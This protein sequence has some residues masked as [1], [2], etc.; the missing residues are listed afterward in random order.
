MSYLRLN[1]AL[2]TIAMLLTAML[3]TPL[4]AAAENSEPSRTPPV[5]VVPINTEPAAANK[6]PLPEAPYYTG[7]GQPPAYSPPAS[8]A[9]VAAPPPDFY[10]RARHL[11]GGSRLLATGGISPLEGA[12]GGG[13]VPWALISGLGDRD[14]I[15]GSAY[16]TQAD[17][18][19]FSLR[20]SGGA[21][22]FFNRVELSYAHLDFGLG[23][24]VPGHSIGLDVIGAKLRVYGDAVYDQDSLIP[25]ISVGVQHKHN[26]DFDLVPKALGARRSDDNDYYIAATKIFLAGLAGRNV[27]ANLTLRATRANQLGIL[28][29]GGDQGDHYQVLPEASLGVFLADHWLVGGEYRMKP[30]NLSVFREDDFKDAFLVWFPIKRLSLTAAWAWLGNIADQD[31]QDALYLSG[32]LAF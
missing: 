28:G 24:T 18:T 22:G 23:T 26:K 8:L 11:V 27:V 3:V 2:T 9:V 20:S 10:D 25:Q 5:D 1:L 29:F 4:S 13:I 12:G 16:Y 15:G 32:Q 6:P 7:I 30:D 31:N 14:Q 19:D 17:P 21:I